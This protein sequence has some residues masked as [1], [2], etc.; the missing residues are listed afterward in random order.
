MGNES[1][2]EA[3][4]MRR[5]KMLMEAMTAQLNKTMLESMNEMMKQNM[6]EIRREIRQAT[7]QGHS[8]ESRR[9]RHTHTPQEHGG[10]QETDNYYERHRS[11]RSGSSSASRGSRRRTRRDHDERRP[12]RDELSGL[13][14]KIPPFH[15]KVDPDAY[16]EWE[17]KI[18][19]VFN[20]KHYTNFQRIQFAAT[21]F[22]DYALSWWDQLVTTR[23]INQEY[24]V[25]TWQ[26]MKSLM[27]KRFVPN[28]YHRD[29]HQKLRK[30][31]QG[32]KTVEEY[33]QEME[34][35]MLRAGISEDREASMA[36]FL[37]GLN[38]EIQDSVEMQHYIEI[39]EMLHKAI[40]VE[41]QIKRKHHSRG[42]YGSSK[43]QYTKEEKPSH[44]RDSKPQPKEE[45]KSSIPYSKE[46]SKAEATSSRTRD[47]KCFKCQGRGHYANECTNKKVMILL[48]NGEYES[49]EEHSGSDQDRSDEG[50]EVEPVKGRLLVTRRL[51][52]LQTKAE[53]TDETM[54]KKLG[55]K[56]QKHPRPYRLQWLNE[57][58]EMRVSNQVL[59]PIAIGRYEDEILCDILPMEASHILLGRPWQFD[60]R[61]VH[62]GFSNKHSFEFNGKK[63]VLVP[64]S[65]KEVQADQLQLQKKKEIDL[66]P[67]QKHHKY[68]SMCCS[69][70]PC[71]QERWSWRMCV[72]CRAI[73]N[74]TVKYRHPIPRL[75]DMLDELHGSSI[76]SKIDLKSGYHQIRMK[77]GD[78]WKTAFKTKH[79]L[80]EWLVM[81]FG[82]TNAPSTFMRLMNHVLRSFIGVF[83]VVYFD[84]ILVYS[85]SLEE[86]IVHVRTVLDV[87]RKEKLFANLKKCTFCTDN[88]VFL[89]F[90][91]S[92]DG[93]KV[94]QEKVKAIQEWPSPKT[95]NEKDVGFKWGEAQETSFQTLKEKLTNSPLLILPDFSKTFEIECDASGIGI[96][97]VL[98]QDRR[99]I[100]YF[101]EKLSGATLNY[102]TYDKELY[103]L[104][105]ALQTWQ[106]YLWPKEF[107]IHTDHESLKYLKGQSKLSKRHARWVEFIE[108]FPYVIKYKQDL[109]VRES[110][111]GS[112]MG[113]SASKYSPFEIV[114]GF[115]PISPLDLMPLPECARVSMDGKKKAEMVQ[116]IHEK[117]RKN[118]IEKTKQYTKRANKG[119]REMIFEV[120]DMVWVHLRKERF[121][122]ER[123]SKLM[124]RIDGPF[125]IIQRIND[126]A[127]KLDLQDEPDLRTNPFQEGGD[128]MIMDQ[129]SKEDKEIMEEPADEDA[130]TMPKG[131]MTR[132]RSKQ[133][134]EAIGGLKKFGNVSN[135]SRVFELKRAINTLVQED[136]ELTKDMGKFKSMWSELESLRPSTTD[137]EVLMERRE[138]DQV[139]G[140]LMTLNPCY[141][142]VIKHI[143]RSPSLPSMEE[144]MAQLQKEEGSLGLFG[145]KGELSIAHQAEE[146]QANKAGYG[147]EDRR[148]RERFSGSCD[149][150]K[151]Q[152]HK[153]SQ[154]WVLH[155]HLKPAK[156]NKDREARAHLSTEAS[157]AGSSAQ[158]GESEGKALASH[159]SGGKGIDQDVIKKSDIEALIRALKE[160]GNKL[161]NTLGYSYTAYRMSSDTDRLLDLIKSSYPEH[162]SVHCSD[163]CDS[164]L[165]REIVPAQGHVMIANGDRIPIRGIG[166]LRLF[167]KESNAFF[168][169]EFTSNLLSGGSNYLLWSRLVKT[170]IGRLGLWSHI[171]DEAQTKPV[172]KEDEDEKEK[173]KALA[174]FKRWVKDDLMVLS[175]LQGSLELHLL[176]AYSY[177]ETPK[178]LWE[179]LQK[180]YGNKTNL[181]RVFELKGAI[182]ALVQDGE[183]F[184]KHLGKFRALW[185]E[186]EGLRPNTTDQ[187]TLAERREQDQVFGLMMTLDP[188]YKDVIAHI[189]RS[190]TLP[191]M[192]EVCAQLQ[193]EEGS[194]G[195]FGGK[196]DLSLAHKAEEVQANKA[197]YKGGDRKYGERLL[198]M[199]EHAYST[200]KALNAS[201]KLLDVIES[202]RNRNDHPRTHIA[203][204]MHK[205][206]IIDSGASHHMISDCKLIKDL[207]PAQGHLEVKEIKV[208]AVVMIKLRWEKEMK[209]SLSKRIR[210]NKKKRV[211]FKRYNP[212]QCKKFNKYL[213]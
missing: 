84:D 72:D 18:E 176:E 52:N 155:P 80:Y 177:C 45:P 99:P 196:K 127:Y 101:S 62:D 58:G 173:E 77:E 9:N 2:E 65:P 105:R 113:H 76:F 96:G 143:L 26:E 175:V 12:Y 212:N 98:M 3:E 199:I 17:K 83:V 174:E 145:G 79:G 71:A 107:V 153:K 163:K 150:C 29:L 54:V 122:K 112:L 67:D 166:K 160:S 37:G 7:G 180:T 187:D 128:D 42:N 124:P 147:G 121:P 189:L 179:V 182:N 181:S 139:F 197:M 87:L 114:Y 102:A 28:H 36:R 46:K 188:A 74:I 111:G 23:R 208:Q 185:N 144:V 56:V 22:Y 138:Q 157:G 192:E 109:F 149:H 35:L 194:I 19:I 137:Q 115:N 134:K 20:C 40:L 63:T 116:Q 170:A 186:L 118:I 43:Y 133:L 169:P 203:Q 125:E 70:S 5:N 48:E 93:V 82:L 10:S 69:S 195:L 161:G 146:M 64:L 140:L 89:G 53:E 136:V 119:R 132:A 34:L 168:M 103:A 178:H 183:E 50:S 198:D 152:G 191:S 100:A 108:T 206:L 209:V 164:K 158:V 120:G 151:R 25:E 123:K 211:E 184:A 91:V 130:L 142:D 44:M 81:P 73:N 51:L 75:D 135:L 78:E 39:E 90:V 30:L 200:E 104:V 6:E 210:L 1:E 94:D 27:R 60:R 126:N 154:C 57:E 61:V 86:H 31:T 88:L 14:L 167:D 68:E 24:P 193:K 117:A 15:G 201:D 11:E 213:S 32:S 131:P 110:H 38:R 66:K 148:P 204:N 55:L 165:I 207:E 202:L 21:E 4:L 129:S 8:N 156:F 85:K 190:T 205:P 92:A 172:V 49:E 33:Y 16:I 171:T 59:I 47:V 41:Q 159:H 97:A 162:S 95:I 13:K 106:H 141:K